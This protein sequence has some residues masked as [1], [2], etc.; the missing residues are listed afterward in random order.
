MTKQYVCYYYDGY[1]GVWPTWFV[2]GRSDALD[3]A[4]YYKR[5]AEARGLTAKIEKVDHER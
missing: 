2:Y 4:I 5:T 1:A 3:V